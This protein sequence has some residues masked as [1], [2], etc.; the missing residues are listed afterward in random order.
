MGEIYTSMEF[1]KF[2]A[3]ELTVG[4]DKITYLGYADYAANSFRDSK[5]G[6]KVDADKGR[7]IRRIKK[8]VENTT[9][10]VTETFYPGGDARKL[11]AWNDRASLTYI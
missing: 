9:T 7:P 1:K 4:T 10:K 11:Y 2:M 8:I 6:Y 3:E 5:D